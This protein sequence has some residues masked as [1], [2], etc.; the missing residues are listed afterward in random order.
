MTNPVQRHLLREALR[1]G[2]LAWLAA[3]PFGLVIVLALWGADGVLAL[4]WFIL[5]TALVV[6]RSL[7]CRR[8]LAAFDSGDARTLEWFTLL[9]GAEGALWALGL[10]LLPAGG[11]D[12][13]VLMLAV[14]TGALFVATAWYGPVLMAFSAFALPL[15]F[16]QLVNMYLRELPNRD[17]VLLCWLLGVSASVLVGWWVRNALA[18]GLNQQLQTERSARAHEQIAT[19][20]GRGREQMR[21]ALDAIDAG[22]S[23]THLA[24]GEVFFSTRYAQILGYDDRD[25]FVKSHR[26]ADALH[27][28][29]RPR[30]LEAMRE[31]VD[32]GAPFREEFRLRNAHASYVWVVARAESVRG[33][34]GRAARLVMSIVDVTERRESEARLAVNERR[35]RALVEASPSLI[36]LCDKRGRL[37]YVSVR[38]CRA[39]YG[40]EPREVVGRS[41]LS[42]NAPEVTRRVMFRRLGRVLRGQPVFDVELTHIAKNGQPVYV[43]V[44]ALPTRD[45]NGMVEGMLGTCSDVTGLKRREHDLDVALRNQQAIFDAAG[46]GIAFARGGRIETANRALAKMLGVTR[47][48]L[49][50]RDVGEILAQQKDWEGIRR[51]TSDAAERGE[52]AN[53]EVMMRTAEGSFGGRN[54]WCQ[55]TSRLVEGDALILVLTDITLLKRREE[56]AWHQA[57]HDELTG[58]PNR[59]LLVEHSRRLLSVAMRQKRMAA[60]LVLDL[61]GFKDVNDVFGHAFGDTILRRV[62]LRL[63]GAL[64]EY[65]VVA[66]TGGDEFVVLLPEIEQPSV[67]T[68]V[69]DKL[70]GAASETLEGPGRSMRIHASVGVALFPNDGH[71]FD[72]LLSRAD[73]AMYAAKAAGKNQFRIASEPL[74]GELLPA[75]PH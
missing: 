39:M 51:A 16:A 62:A 54:V 29:D 74:T 9:A 60:V 64:R 21:L 52:A 2:Q 28:D 37:T 18:R 19:E 70:I 12:R 24:S 55:L 36:W 57:N 1:L 48:W 40:F 43:T 59:R 11:A 31:H 53:H 71:D 23:D 46:E 35:Y 61:D 49:I 8:W 10:I 44:S 26:F 41:V 75:R 73:A 72:T 3:L 22:V 5:L 33:P 42:F 32:N 56:L 50:G 14:S 34:D 4:G 20:L 38:A 30:V 67:A 66:R 58:L 6:M 15:A 45:D 68:L 27:A 17:L 25:A 13:T 69:A 47:E 63:S 65:D 7:C